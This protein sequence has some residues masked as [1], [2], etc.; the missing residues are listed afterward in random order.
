MITPDQQRVADALDRTRRAYP[1]S[2]VT[3]GQL[4]EYMDDLADLPTEAVLQALTECRRTGEFFPTLFAIRTRAV[5]LMGGE[6]FVDPEVAWGEVRRNAQRFG[7]AG[8][9]VTWAP[10]GERAVEVRMEWSS[11]LIAEAVEAVGWRDICM[12]D[13]KQLSTL[14]AQFR[15]ALAALQ[16]RRKDAAVSGRA[17]LGGPALPAGSPGRQLHAAVSALATGMRMDRPDPTAPEPATPARLRDRI[18]PTPL[19]RTS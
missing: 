12:I 5:E 9:R 1:H 4:D 2:T 19:R 3:D 7:I 13:D 14:R 16:R 15:D 6:L 10:D 17:S 8:T 11:P 18:G